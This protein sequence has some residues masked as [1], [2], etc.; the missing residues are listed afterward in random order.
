MIELLLPLP[1]DLQQRNEQGGAR[2]S[3]L[4]YSYYQGNI[5]NMSE[6]S[7]NVTELKKHRLFRE[8][9]LKQAEHHM[10]DQW[11]ALHGACEHADC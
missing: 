1:K 3:L 8:K 11:L 2:I 9:D 5:C 10:H 4:I 6:L 7:V